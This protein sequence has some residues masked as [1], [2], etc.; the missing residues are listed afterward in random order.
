[1]VYELRSYDIDPAR[2]EDYLTWANDRAMPI[3]VGTHGF[4]LVGFWRAL[5]K[6][7]E[8]LPTTNVHWLIA[9]ESEQEMND[10]WAAARASAA[11]QEAVREIS[12]PATGQSMYH[13]RRQSTL[14]RGIPRSPLQ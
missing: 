1:M 10:R 6:T 5:A 2:V 11:F 4:R 7:N 13:L 12:D 8:S 14:L 3:L 9:W